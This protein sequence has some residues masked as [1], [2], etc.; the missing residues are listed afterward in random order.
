MDSFE[1]NKVAGAVLMTLL[2]MTVIGHAGDILVPEPEPGKSHIEI[3]GAEA[4]QT[5]QQAKAPANQ[6]FSVY[7]AKANPQQG[8]KAAHICETCH[9]LQKGKGPKIGP[10]LWGVVG[11]KVASNDG[12]QYSDAIKKIGGDWDF[13]KLNEWLASPQ[14]MAP[15][16]KMT[17]AGIP[18]EQQRA[19]VIAYLNTQS[20]KP[21]PLPKVTS[22]ASAQPA[23]GA[24]AEPSPSKSAQPAQE[25][26]APA[27]AGL[28]QRLAK[29]NPAEGAKDARICE[30]CHNFEKG[31]GPKIGPDLWDVVGRKVASQEKFSYSDAIKKIGGNWDFQKLDEWL[32]SPQ[33]MAPGTKMTFAGVPDAQKRA[34]IIAFLNSKSDKPQPLPK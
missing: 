22:A 20:D 15:G 19:D 8:A 12:F 7:L 31:K 5:T 34:D 11:R 18:D 32:T 28:D 10:D 24:A 4:A 16:T 27:N 3:A 6:P 21:E 29:A 9:N 23:Q 33:K 25:A 30:T 14:K 17:F 1:W 13:D 26:K 2:I